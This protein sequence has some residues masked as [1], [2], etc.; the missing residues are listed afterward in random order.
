MR[1]VYLEIT[2]SGQCR[3]C[4]ALGSGCWNVVEGINKLCFIFSSVIF[5]YSIF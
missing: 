3:D 5:K 1:S 4:G 2:C